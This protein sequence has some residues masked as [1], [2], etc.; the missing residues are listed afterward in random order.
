MESMGSLA[1]NPRARH[2]RGND[3]IHAMGAPTDKHP[4]WVIEGNGIG[5]GGVVNAENEEAA[6]LAYIRQYYPG[7]TD[8][9][10]FKGRDVGRARD[11]ITARVYGSTVQEEDGMM[12]VRSREQEAA[13]RETDLELW[14]AICDLAGQNLDVANRIW[15]SPRMNELKQIDNK[16]LAAGIKYGERFCWGQATYVVGLPAH[17]MA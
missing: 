1:G 14:D 5:D 6:K 16:L 10:T 7:T 4:D 3:P 9:W 11:T 15:T 17:C 8:D 2:A 13:S 12:T